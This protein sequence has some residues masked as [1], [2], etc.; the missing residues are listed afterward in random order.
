MKKEDVLLRMIAVSGELPAGLVGE[1]VGSETYAAALITRL[2]KE[3]Y[4]SVRNAGGYKGYV[5]RS[6]GKRYLL[7]KY[8]D[9]LFFFLSGSAQTN[10]VKSEPEKRLRLYRMSE[11][12]VFFMKM[13]IEIFQSQKPDL[14]NGFEKSGKKAVYYGSLE[15]KESAEAIKGSRA[16]GVLITGDT[17]Y[18]VY[19]TMNKR[20][21]WAKKMETAMRTWTERMLL[22]GGGLRRADSLILGDS[23]EFL[24]ELLN[25]D[26]GVRKNLYQVDDV[27]ERYYYI[28]R[29]S[30]A[31]IQM[32]FLLTSWKREK[33]KKLLAT[34]VKYPRRKEY[35][36]SEG[37]DKNM[38]PIYFCHELD[39]RHLCR[40]KQ[41]IGWKQQGTIICMDY[42]A[43]TLREYFG[44]EVRVR[45]LNADKIMEYLTKGRD[46]E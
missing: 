12:W 41:E 3:N 14:G 20:M 24:T 36:I 22:I 23:M 15:Y 7:E 45:E 8:E 5:L 30:I 9:D 40:I 35:A 33:M 10:H 37:F 17:A 42:Q 32:E 1:I 16:C 21:K 13:G 4:I 2:K 18:V 19:N 25:S 27:Y 34:L 31:R 46:G 43:N 6:K 28:P 26:S 39:M 44:K 38:Q 11:V 29:I